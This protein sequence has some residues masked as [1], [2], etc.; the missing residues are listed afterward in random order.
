MHLAIAALLAI[1]A[2]PAMG[3]TL[4]PALERTLAAA[5]PDKA[6]I[7]FVH[8]S[9]IEPALRAV[10]ESGLK[11]VEP[12]NRVGIAVARG[13]PKAIRRLI[14]HPAV[15]F[16]EPNVPAR[17]FLD[18]AHIA[19]RA[20]EARQP[21]SGL[22]GP[23]ALPFDGTGISIAIN[24]SGIDG[25][26]PMFV[27]NGVS[28]VVRNLKQTC[29]EEADGCNQWIDADNSDF[30]GHG[31]AVAG[32][33][34]GY[35]RVT[36][37][38][39]TVRGVAPGAKL[40]GLGHEP[41]QNYTYGYISGLNWVLEHH[42]NPCGDNSCPPIRVVINA[43]GPGD[44]C[45]SRLNQG[46]A[47]T[48]LSDELVAAGIV[49]TYAV[50]NGE[51]S[52]GLLLRGG[53]GSDN[54]VLYLAT[55]PTPGIIGV[56]NYDDQDIGDRDHMLHPSSSRGLKSDPSTY[57]DLAA[58]GS[59]VWTACSIQQAN[60]VAI[61]DPQYSAFSGTSA[62]SPYAGG[63]AAVLL[64][65]NPAMTPGQIEAILE[66]T[67]YQFGPPDYVQ[68]PRNPDHSTSFDRGHGLID[69]AAALA[70]V[71]ARPVPTATRPR[72]KAIGTLSF[73][74]TPQPERSTGL[75]SPEGCNTESGAAQG[76][77]SP[78]AVA[79]ICHSAKLLGLAVF[80]SAPMSQPLII[81]GPASMI[82]YLADVYDPVEGRQSA[83]E[84]DLYAVA[85]DD[86]ETLIGTGV[87]ISRLRP[88]RNLG[89]F[90]QAW[91]V[92]P[93]GT[94]L[95]LEMG[96]FTPLTPGRRGAYSES[97]QLFGGSEYSD[98]GITFTVGTFDTRTSSAGPTEPRG[99]LGGALPLA[100]L[101]PGLLAGLCV[102]L[103]RRRGFTP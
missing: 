26:H 5:D 17:L 28:K 39:H 23:T 88:G 30:N 101:A 34:A 92:L 73:L 6:L 10:E 81:G 102:G 103:A 9:S 69:L 87:A 35:E 44:A 21:E 12:W 52:H 96:D 60:C 65:A 79:G 77:L 80:A 99:L 95:R 41:Q 72:Y 18:S 15:L 78:N 16:V 42:A 51:C 71:L 93:T 1:F 33:A 13:T 49:V 27:E 97:R 4:D 61:S 56:A 98:S 45:D 62:A 53:D 54:R 55:N 7:V 75:T 85:P 70:S 74:L 20:E 100:L 48:K 2:F 59:N 67:S 90:H 68:D 37:T 29:V 66:N 24:D 14:T 50:G 89:T 25:L 31:T 83:M 11:L 82:V 8:A 19:S 84:Y 94:R 91:R 57:P 43:W 76:T 32:I 58:P 64:S 38:G 3:S 63:A 36:A 46:S 47:A 40:I 86:S 22:L